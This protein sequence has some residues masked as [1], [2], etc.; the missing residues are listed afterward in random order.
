M[1]DLAKTVTLPHYPGTFDLGK[2]NAAI[3][4]VVHHETEA[5]GR[6]AL[7]HVG[8]WPASEAVTYAQ[9]AQFC[10]DNQID[11]NE[12]VAREPA[13]LDTHVPYDQHDPLRQIL[14]TAPREANTLRE[15]LLEH[16]HIILPMPSE[17]DPLHGVPAWDDA[18]TLLAQFM[19]WLAAKGQLV[20][21]PDDA[22]DDQQDVVLHFLADQRQAARESS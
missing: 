17:G 14:A 4:A 11:P 19:V 7:V 1:P 21:V 16:G 13:P 10:C 12:Y 6:Y 18:E 5:A 22:T 3:T 2:I 15:H 8:G 20:N 9:A